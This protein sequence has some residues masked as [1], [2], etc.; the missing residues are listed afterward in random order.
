MWFLQQQNNAQGHWSNN[1]QVTRQVF[2]ITISGVL[3]DKTL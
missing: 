1:F 2:L 3:E